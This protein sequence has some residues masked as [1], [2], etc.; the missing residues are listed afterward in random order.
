MGDPETCLRAAARIQ[1]ADLVP[2]ARLSK[3][4]SPVI[5]ADARIMEGLNGPSARTNIRA[6]TSSEHAPRVARMGGLIPSTLG[7]GQRRGTTTIFFFRRDGVSFVLSSSSKDVRDLCIFSSSLRTVSFAIRRSPASI[8]VS[9]RNLL[10]LLRAGRQKPIIPIFLVL[11]PA[12]WLSFP[13]HARRKRSTIFANSF[14]TL[15]KSNIRHF[16][17]PCVPSPVRLRWRSKRLLPVTNKRRANRTRS[18]HFPGSH[19]VMPLRPRLRFRTS[20]CRCSNPRGRPSS[21]FSKARPEN[22]LGTS[23]LPNRQLRHRAKGV[24]LTICELL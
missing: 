6:R 23:P 12:G 16:P 9:F 18:Y 24:A 5:H 17:R 21:I 3:K 4:S 15:W 2:L 14:V 13:G 11:A 22:Y 10:D 8:L 1:R 20:L 19:G 7:H